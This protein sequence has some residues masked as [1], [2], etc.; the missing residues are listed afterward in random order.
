MDKLVERHPLHFNLLSTSPEFLLTKTNFYLQSLIERT[1]NSQVNEFAN[2]GENIFLNISE[3]T[4]YNKA[5]A[6]GVRPH[7]TTD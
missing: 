5:L 7:D 3:S 2:I 6:D 4:V 1:L